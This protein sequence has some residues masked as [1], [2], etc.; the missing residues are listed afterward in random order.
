MII[1]IHEYNILF[2]AIITL[3]ASPKVNLEFNPFSS[4]PAPWGAVQDRV[5]DLLPPPGSPH[6]PLGWSPRKRGSGQASLAE[7]SAARGS[8]PSLAARKVAALNGLS[9]EPCW[10][11]RAGGRLPAHPGAGG[12]ADRWSL[13]TQVRG[14]VTVPVPLRLC[15]VARCVQHSTGKTQEACD[16]RRE[17]QTVSFWRRNDCLCCSVSRKDRI[18]TY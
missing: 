8:G 1:Q 7:T 13:H 2:A 12:R 10:R 18:A 9:T 17:N 15:T 5:P 6:H 16:C 14:R 3:G 4:R 11:R